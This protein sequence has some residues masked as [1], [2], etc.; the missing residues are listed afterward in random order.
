MTTVLA[1]DVG[2]EIHRPRGGRPVAVAYRGDTET[3]RLTGP[4]LRWRVA[5]RSWLLA[6]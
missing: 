6:R 1:T 3:A 2:W 5:V 4:L